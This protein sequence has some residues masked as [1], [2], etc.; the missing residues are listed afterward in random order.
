MDNREELLAKAKRDYPNGTIFNS[1]GGSQRCLI[2]DFN[3]LY[4]YQNEIY[5]DKATN[6]KS[7]RVYSP[8]KWAEIVFSPIIKSN[9]YF[10]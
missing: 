7:C 2:K 6:G 5:A 8:G 4:W 10:Y 9:Y 1:T 3:S